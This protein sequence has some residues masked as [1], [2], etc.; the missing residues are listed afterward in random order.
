MLIELSNRVC[1]YK[2]EYLIRTHLQSYINRTICALQGFNI[3]SIHKIYVLTLTV[4]SYFYMVV[5]L[6]NMIL[7]N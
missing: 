7:S 5:N 1:V 2:V 4:L 3:R 6:M